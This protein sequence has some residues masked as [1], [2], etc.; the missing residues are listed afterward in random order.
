MS[1]AL[2]R[3]YEEPA[4]EDGYRVLVDRLW[5]RGIS[6]DKAGIDEW[7]KEIAPTDRLRKWFHQNP[8]QWDKFRR[9]YLAELKKHREKLRPL[10]ERGK[11]ERVTLVFGGRDERHNNAVVVKQYLK[12]LGATDST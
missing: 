5:P 2:K 7:L 4:G 3:I 6:K 9:S 12:M 8:S 11:S 1:I 10:A